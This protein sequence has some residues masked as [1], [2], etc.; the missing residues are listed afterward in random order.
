GEALSKNIPITVADRP[1]SAESRTSRP[2]PIPMQTTTNVAGKMLSGGKSVRASWLT[3]ISALAD[4][5]AEAGLIDDCLKSV[6]AIDDPW[7]K[8]LVMSQLV[9][10]F[11]KA[12]RHELAERQTATITFAL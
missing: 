4:A 7:T 12:G 9:Q 10:N 11:T 6:A 5:Q 2:S 3:A 8:A 1:S